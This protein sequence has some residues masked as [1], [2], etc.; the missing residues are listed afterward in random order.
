MDRS[1]ALRRPLFTGISL[2]LVLL[3]LVP[4]TG[5]LHLLLAS[6]IYLWQGGNV[7]PAE[8]DALVGKRVVV[9]CRPPASSDFSLAGASRQLNRA[10]S[11]MLKQNVKKIEVVDPRE[12]DNWLDESDTGDYVD[13]GHAVK[14][15]IVVVV[16]M[17]RFDLYKGR[18]LYQGN[19]DLSLLVHDMSAGGELIWDRQLGQILF[20]HNAPIP[21]ADKPQEQF[22]REFVA[23]LANRVAIHFYKHDPTLNF[24]TDALA[25][26]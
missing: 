21:A 25:N 20:P 7:V 12:V 18:T 23:I 11:M 17:E 19:A 13:L 2:V 4:S 26:R 6:G 15:D 16:D 8:C 14:A 9:V 1:P 5:C 22:Q 10:I 24:A 3:S